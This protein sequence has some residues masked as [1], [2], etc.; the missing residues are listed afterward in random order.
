MEA[1]CSC[2]EFLQPLAGLW[3]EA[4][5]ICADASISPPDA[6]HLATAVR[7]GCDLLVTRDSDFMKLAGDYIAASTPE[8]AEPALK[9]AGFAV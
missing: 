4:E 7:V 8:R 3:D 2:L 5:K 6:I 9:A 1:K